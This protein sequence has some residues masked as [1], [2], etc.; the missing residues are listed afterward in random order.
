M[1]EAKAVV[2]GNPTF[3]YC[4][5]M[6]LGA[7]G[8]WISMPL[9]AP[10]TTV[11]TVVVVFDV[12]IF[13]RSLVVAVGSGVLALLS[14]TVSLD[15]DG[16]G[17]FATSAQWILSVFG[18]SDLMTSQLVSLGPFALLCDFIAV[19]YE[20]FAGDSAPAPTND[21]DPDPIEEPPD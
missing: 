3:H 21:G 5:L 13:V 1:R 6:V 10:Q 15:P 14:A 8:V 18:L 11:E 9:Y 12:I 16:H 17:W 7:W 4:L 19:M 2:L 20:A